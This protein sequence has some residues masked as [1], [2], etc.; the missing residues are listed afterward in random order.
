[1]LDYGKKDAAIMLG[2]ALILSISIWSLTTYL[3]SPLRRFPGPFFAGESII[4]PNAG[5]T[6][7]RTSSTL[8]SS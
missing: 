5:F 8:T 6:A 4:I 7:E 3:L 1:M 2:Y